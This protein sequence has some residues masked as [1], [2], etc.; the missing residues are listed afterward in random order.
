MTT[1]AVAVTGL[2]ET[3]EAVQGAASRARTLGPV[4]NVI[5]QQITTGIDDSFRGGLAF[6]GEPFAPNAPSTIKAKGSS[7][8][9]IDTSRFRASSVARSDGRSAVLFGTN[10]PY[11]GPVISGFTRKG[12]LRHTA[13][14]PKRA[15]GAAWS[16]TVR[17]RNPFPVTPSGDWIAVSRGQVLRDKIV[18]TLTG[19]IASGRLG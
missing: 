6:T 4:L 8:P 3:L 14:K 1:V 12:T 10:T 9:A 2:K 19:Y 11:A 15:A 13:Y 18:R 7:K 16:V 17:G 5:A